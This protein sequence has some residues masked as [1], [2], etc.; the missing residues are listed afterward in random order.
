MSETIVCTFDDL[1]RAQSARD[2]LA[3]EGFDPRAMH[4]TVRDDEAGPAEGGF[5]AGNGEVSTGGNTAYRPKPLKN[6]YEQNYQPVRW[7][8]GIVLSVAIE[9]PQDRSRVK[10][11]VGR[12]GAVRLDD[13]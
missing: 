8:A 6:A 1:A 10:D 3:A 13:P 9:H 12:F 2:A 4:L 7:R 11:I 5:V